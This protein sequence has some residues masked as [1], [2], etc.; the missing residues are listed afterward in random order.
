M[1]QARALAKFPIPVNHPKFGRIVFKARADFIAF[2]ESVRREVV[3]NVFTDTT[4]SAFE[5]SID[6]IT[7]DAKNATDSMWRIEQA[8]ENE[9][10]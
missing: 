8:L 10:I 5:A 4:E 1:E 2:R 9:G 7:R 3:G 6:A